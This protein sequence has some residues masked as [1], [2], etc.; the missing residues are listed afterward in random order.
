MGFILAP[1]ALI[2]FALV[3]FINYFSVIIVNLTRRAFFKTVSKIKFEFAFN[4]DVF[5]NYLLKDTWNLI[6]AWKVKPF[7]IFGET[8][9][10]VLG[11]LRRDSGISWFGWL[12]SWFL[13]IIWFT[14]WFKGGH[15]KASIMS[16]ER[17]EEIRKTYAKRTF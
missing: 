12:F 8:I 16:E 1:I 3:G 9:S 7:G 10:S 11:K 13:D 15:C 4:V 6:F 17:I 5:G 14:D 2:L